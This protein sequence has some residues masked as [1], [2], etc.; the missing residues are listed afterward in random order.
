MSAEVVM[1]GF[2][3]F[4]IRDEVANT[5]SKSLLILMSFAISKVDSLPE[6]PFAYQLHA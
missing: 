4:I 5:I 2:D 3:S 6:I 1:D